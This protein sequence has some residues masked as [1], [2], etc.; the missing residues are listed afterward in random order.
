MTTVRFYWLPNST[1]LIAEHVLRKIY[2]CTFQA[3]TPEWTVLLN[4]I[5]IYPSKFPKT[6]FSHWPQMM[7]F[8]QPNFAHYLFQ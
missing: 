5:S 3:Q 8:M 1:V 6:F 4:K 7:L 2:H